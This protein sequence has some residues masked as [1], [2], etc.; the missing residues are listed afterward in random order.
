MIFPPTDKNDPRFEDY[1]NFNRRNFEKYLCHWTEEMHKYKADLDCCS[2]WSYTTMMPKPKVA[3]VDMISGDFDPFLSVDR[4]RTECRYLQNTGLPWELQSWAFD[5]IK[6][7]D[8]CAKMPAQIKQEA[9]GGS[10]YL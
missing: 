5:C 3:Q 7:Q 9:E 8:E 2:N 4:A 10:K 1:K 6:D